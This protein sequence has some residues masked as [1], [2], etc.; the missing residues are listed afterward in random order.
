MVTGMSKNENERREREREGRED[1]TDKG[2]VIDEGTRPRK[3]KR[4]GGLERGVTEKG[5]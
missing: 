4:L 5:T 1:V 2:N 3:G